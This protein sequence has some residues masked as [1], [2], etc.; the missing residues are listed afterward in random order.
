M[1]FADFLGFSRDVKFSKK[2]NEMPS[3]HVCE[4]IKNLWAEQF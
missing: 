2:H 3:A 4:K 1:C